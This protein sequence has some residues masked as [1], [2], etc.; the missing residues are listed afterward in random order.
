MKHLLQ[1]TLLLAFLSTSEAYALDQQTDPPAQGS[2]HKVKD[3]IIYDDPRY[4]ASFPSVIKSG[5]DDY[6]VAFRRAPDRRIFGES[7]NNHVDPNSY[8]MMVRSADGEQWS[9]PPQLIYA[10]PL[11][12]SQ[13]PCLL[14]LRDGTLLCSSYVWSFVRPGAELPHARPV[15]DI[16]GGVR[17]L[18]GYLIRSTDGGRSWSNPITPPHVAQE[19]YFNALGDPL[20]AYNR[21]ALCEGRNGRIYWVV[22]VN[23]SVPVRKTS[24]HLIVSDDKGLSWSYSGLV[25]T[26]D[27]ASFNEAS[28]YETP[29][30]DLVAFLRT[31]NMDDQASVARSTDGGKRFTWEKMGFRGHPLNALRLPDD[32]VLLTYGY[33]HQPYGIRAR[34]LNAECTDFATA[35][36]IILRDDGDNSDIGYTWP[37]LLDEDRVLVVYYFNRENGTR[38]IAGTILELR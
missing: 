18:G 31:A 2:Y 17:F 26:D 23:D 27:K 13:D 34:V 14:R 28:V 8:L 30:G 1:L 9:S 15:M 19:I 11:G 37:V 35:P 4:Y 24:N 22:A 29:R 3:I 7:G 33:R 12:G 16:G 38:H 10:H 36:E 25:A 32:R 20:P 21:G 5:T 6:I